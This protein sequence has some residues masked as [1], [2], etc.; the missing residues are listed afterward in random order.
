M[1]SHGACHL[2][3]RVVVIVGPCGLVSINRPAQGRARL[4]FIVTVFHCRMCVCLNYNY[5]KPTELVG[6]GKI[7]WHSTQLHW[8]PGGSEMRDADIT[9]TR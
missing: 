1:T 4:K 7:D 8:L 6:C 5:T 9:R 3:Q 2:E